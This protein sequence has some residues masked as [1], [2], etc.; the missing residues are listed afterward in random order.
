MALPVA[1]EVSQRFRVAL[2]ST[3]TAPPTGDANNNDESASAQSGSVIVVDFER[4]YGEDVMEHKILGMRQ[5]S[6]RVTA[7][8]LSGCGQWV[9][10]QTDYAEVEIHPLPPASQ[11]EASDEGGAAARM[12]PIEE[13]NELPDVSSDI[14]AIPPCTF[15]LTTERAEAERVLSS[16][17]SAVLPD[18]ALY[19]VPTQPKLTLAYPLPPKPPAVIENIVVIAPLTRRWQVYR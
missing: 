4:Q 3:V 1:S 2:Y 17:P 8:A 13:D 16:L 11:N 7:M 18:P 19:F 5:C 6:S 9:A 12:E 15:I 14:A 10:V